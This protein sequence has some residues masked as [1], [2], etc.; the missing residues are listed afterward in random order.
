VDRENHKALAGQSPMLALKAV[1][2]RKKKKTSR[3]RSI[4]T[5]WQSFMFSR[6]GWQE[7][8]SNDDFAS[9]LKFGRKTDEFGRLILTWTLNNWDACAATAVGPGKDWPTIP[10][11]AFFDT[12]QV[13]A[14]TL[15]SEHDLTPDEEEAVREAQATSLRDFEELKTIYSLGKEA[16]AENVLA[17]LKHLGRLAKCGRGFEV[18]GRAFKTVIEV[19]DL[20][21]S[22]NNFASLLRNLVAVIPLKSSLD[23]K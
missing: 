17:R 19:A 8:L 21:R 5:I 12:H 20:Y 10:Q 2:P 18:C 14:F 16:L 13:V 4:P 6:I 23:A 11:V 22:D 15:W 7:K 3:R 1:H 9:L